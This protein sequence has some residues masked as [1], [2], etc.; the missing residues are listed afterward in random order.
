MLKELIDY[1]QVDKKGLREYRDIG[2]SLALF[3][4]LIG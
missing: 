4:A 3:I 1:W 2:D